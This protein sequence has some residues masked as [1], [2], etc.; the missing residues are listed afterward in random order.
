MRQ[1][2][3]WHA[4]C[5]IDTRK[6]VQIQILENYN[7]SHKEVSDQ[8]QLFEEVSQEVQREAFRSSG[9]G[10]ARNVLQDY[11]LQDNVRQDSVRQDRGGQQDLLGFL[12]Y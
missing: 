8:Q 11:S 10:E 5:N 12:T 6:A 9:L 2:L 3:I 4:V 1:L 7:G